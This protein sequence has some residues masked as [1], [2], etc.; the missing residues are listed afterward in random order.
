MKMVNISKRQQPDHR[1]DNIQKPP[2]Q[3]E[4]PSPNGGPQLVPK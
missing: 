3:G 4:N 1:A 2:R